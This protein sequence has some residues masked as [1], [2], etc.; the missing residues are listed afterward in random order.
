MTDWVNQVGPYEEATLRAD[1]PSVIGR[2]WRAKRRQTDTAT[3][4]DDWKDIATSSKV[5]SCLGEYEKVGRQNSIFITF[6]SRWRREGQM[7]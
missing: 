7:T 2:T 5:G 6:S 1:R 4:G 3:E